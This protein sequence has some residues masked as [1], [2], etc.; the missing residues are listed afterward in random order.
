MM[1][2]RRVRRVIEQLRPTIQRDGGDIEL[3]DIM[4]DT[5]HIRFHGTCIICP[6]SEVTLKAGIEQAITSM[7]P[8]IKEVIRVP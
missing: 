1:I 7:V 8:E 4:D 3:V 6:S 2:E 5:V